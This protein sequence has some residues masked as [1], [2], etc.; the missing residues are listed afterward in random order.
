[1][2]GFEVGLFVGKKEGCVEGNEIGCK[3]GWL[4]GKTDDSLKI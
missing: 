1:L 2:E 3:L 4:E